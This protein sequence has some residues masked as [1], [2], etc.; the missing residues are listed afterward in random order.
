MTDTNDL[1]EEVCNK[2]TMLHLNISPN[3]KPLYHYTTAEGLKGILTSRKIWFTDY[4]Y[5]NDPGEIVYGKNYI[6]KI[7][8]K[9]SSPHIHFIKNQ[10]EKEIF[11]KHSGNF[12]VCSF[13][14]HA[15]YYPAW[16]F[17]GDDG[18]GFAIEFSADF[19]KSNGIID[20]SKNHAMFTEVLYDDL[21]FHNSK[22]TDL[23]DNI[24]LELSSRINNINNKKEKSK[25]LIE[26][27]GHFMA[28]FPSIK[29]PDYKTEKEYRLVLIEL[30]RN[31]KV[32]IPPDEDF[33]KPIIPR[34]S[35]K[36]F[37]KHIY[38]EIVRCEKQIDI[39]Y[40]QMNFKPKMI[41]KII[42]G[43]AHKRSEKII[44]E[45]R[46]LIKSIKDFNH[47]TIEHSAIQ[48]TP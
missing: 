10:I 28:L 44:S 48:Y 24:V 7:L 1:A 12:Y 47:I 15:D 19:F 33:E 14:L 22:Y 34:K 29:H 2:L 27:T 25:L 45:L 46:E 4:N 11:R 30:R 9:Y 31:G 3:A 37:H 23:V 17:Y 38:P 8:E 40:I 16:R 20:L 21:N 43:P 26:L 35:K 36:I 5:L 18:S 6:F 39:P 32:L 41:S 42:I 13:C